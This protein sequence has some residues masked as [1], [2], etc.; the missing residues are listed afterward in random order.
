MQLAVVLIGLA[1]KH[2]VSAVFEVFRHRRIFIF[3]THYFECVTHL[4][5]ARREAIQNLSELLIVNEA[6]HLEN[7]LGY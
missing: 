7:P 1:G 5:F 6:T 3:A 4:S 2:K